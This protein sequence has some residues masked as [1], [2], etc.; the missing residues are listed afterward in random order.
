MNIKLDIKSIKTKIIRLRRTTRT[1]KRLTT[2]KVRGSS[3]NLYNDCG[4]SNRNSKVLTQFSIINGQKATLGSY[5]WIVSLRFINFNSLSHI[6]AGS[7]ISRQ[8]ILT[9]AHCLRRTDD[10]NKYVIVSGTVKLDEQVDSEDIFLISKVFRHPFYDPDRG[11]ND[12]AVVKLTKP[13]KYTERVSSV[14]LPFSNEWEFLINKN[15]FVAGWGSITGFNE[16]SA[17][18]NDILEAK[19]QILNKDKCFGLNINFLCALDPK[20]QS[21]VCFGDSG[22]GL[23]Y[24]DKLTSK[25]VLY[26]V[27]NYVFQDEEKKCSYEMPSLYAIVPKYLLW[28]NATIN[29]AL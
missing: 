2:T 20:L 5:P 18:S 28:I 25:W 17:L 6:C 13:I 12:I 22:G 7:I 8:Y 10:V 27:T 21:N 15:V 26:G 14:C 24:F 1:S 4:V 11:L 3:Q 9:A 23:V 19:L 16:K 29:L